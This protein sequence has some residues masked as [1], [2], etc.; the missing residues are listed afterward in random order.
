MSNHQPEL[1]RLAR[2]VLNRVK[3]AQEEDM[4]K[5]EFHVGIDVGKDELFVAVTDR[6]PRKFSHTRK[7][8]RSLVSWVNELSS[9]LKVVTAWNRPECIVYLWRI[10]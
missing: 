5:S 8:V 3:L 7:G 1:T 6:K 2:G 9:S 10:V 4:S